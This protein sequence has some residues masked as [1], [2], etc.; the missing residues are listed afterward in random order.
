MKRSS[1]SR[2]ATWP[3]PLSFAL[4]LCAV[5]LFVLAA[6]AGARSVLP[7]PRSDSDFNDT[8]ASATQSVVLA[9]VVVT[10]PPTIVPTPT[11]TPLPT[12]TPTPD[13]LFVTP[14][15]VTL[16][17][18]TH[19]WQTWNNCGP[20]TLSMLLSHYGSTLDQATIG[21]ALRPHADDKNVGPQ[22]LVAYALNHGFAGAM[23]VGGSADLLRVLLA[24]D[25]PVL[26]ETWHEAEP[27][28]G[29]G[30]YRLLTGYDDATG[31]W[32]AYDSYDASN[33]VVPEGPYQGIRLAYD[34]FDADWQVFN[35]TYLIIYP[36]TR[37]EVVQRILA[38]QL[39]AAAMWRAALTTAQQ[40]IARTPDDAFA[41]FNVGSNL[42]AL[43]DLPGAAAAFDRA[44][45]LGLPWRMLWYQFGPFE[46]YYA[47]GRYEEVITLA[48]ATIASGADIEELHYWK[49]LAL[50]AQGQADL[51]AAA[52]RYALT[53]NPQYA[54][55]M[56][57]LT[58]L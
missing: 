26:V 32:L 36:P 25:F 33:L 46:A 42:V 57:A 35:R 10:L 29:L 16:S 54:P 40:E 30:H 45:A 39:D 37:G 8:E 5:A 28:D 2:S 38:D 34:A 9:P 27:G 4:G 47:M 56:T 19:A 6:I 48:E 58:Q 14:P 53:L 52:W 43:D 15:A 3:N 44:R 55:A 23:R 20:A 1:L 13:L 18:I 17:G 12:A 24:N 31:D 49:G 51:A 11:A 50:A 7:A 41:W 22:E 21:A